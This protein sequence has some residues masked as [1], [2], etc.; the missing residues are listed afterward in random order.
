MTFVARSPK[1]REGFTLIELLIV[2]AI[3]A[4]LALTIALVLNPAEILKKSRDSQRLSD[5][6]TMKTALGI[7]LTTTSTPY[8]AG[9][10][11]NGPCKSG[12][13][14]GTYANGDNIFYSYPSDTPGASITDTS[15]DGGSSSVPSS[16]QAT[17]ANSGKTDATGW[18][19]VNLD[20][21]TT[22]SPISNFPIDPVNTIASVGAVASTDLVYRYVCNSSSLTFEID[23]QLESAAY[24][25]DDDRRKKDG[26]NNNNYLEVGT[27]L[28]LLGTGTDF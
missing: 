5:L 27:N 13:T 23:A 12:A 7:Y 26:G 2:V 21:L 11:T 9:G 4:I 14:S 25:A 15:L 6:S 16:S 17:V 20:S 3:I 1:L 22:G 28:L 18:V 24:T 10:G 19:P 8:L